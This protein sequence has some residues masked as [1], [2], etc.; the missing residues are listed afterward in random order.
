[1]TT[2]NFDALF[3][4][5][6]VALIGAS[7]RPG[8]VGHV[9]AHN[10]IAGGFDGPILPVN[11]HE[12]AIGGSLCYPSVDK[13]P[14]VPDLAVIATPPA[15]VPAIVAQLGALGCRA[16]VVV[17][18]GFGEGGDG[19]D[20][21]Q[22]MLDAAKPHL[23]RI[24]GPNCLGLMVPGMGLNASFAHLAPV[25]GD[26][27]F[28][29]QSGAIATTV[30]DW[31][32]GRGLGFSHIIS[33]GDMS[34]VD[35]G[36]LL[37]HLALDPAVRSILLYVETV[38][39]PR[40]FMSAARIA[41]RIKPVI[42][43]KAGRSQ[44]GAKAAFSHTG[45]LAGS[46]LVY[47][48]AFRRAGML[49]VRELRELFEAAETLAAGIEVRGDRLTIVTNGGGAGVMAVDALE[50]AGGRLAALS[51]G[52]RTALDAVLPKN[53]SRANPIDIIGDASGERY[54]KALEIVGGEAES[55]DAVLVMNCPTG[56]VDGAEVSGSVIE[57]A[58]AGTTP[59]LACWLGEAT[60][61]ANRARLRA[62]KVPAYETPDEA[63][64]AF[65]QLVT[66]GRN[67]ALLMETPPL[68]EA[69]PT[70]AADKAR[71][72]I[73]LVRGDGRSVLTA[74]EARA[75]LDAYA[76]P[77]LATEVAATPEDAARLA[78]AMAGPV[79]LKILSPDI[80]HKSDVGGV[81]LD[82]ATPEAVRTAAETM[83]TDVRAAAPAARITGFTVQAM[84]VRPRAQELILGVI[85]DR[86]FGPALLFGHGG[87]AVEVIGD[88]VMGLPPLN[89]VLA[90]EMMERTRVIRL[91]KGYRDRPPADLDA[92]A[93]TLV[94]LAQLAADL[95][96]I[97]ELDIN[98]LLADETGVLALDARV[99]L[100]P[101]D[102]EPRRLAIRPYPSGLERTIA[103]RDGRAFP[104]R[105]IRPTDAFLLAQMT[106]R[107]SPEDL[108]LRFLGPV[109]ELA[110]EAAARLTQI[111][112]DREMAFVAFEP[113]SGA[114]AGLARLIGD[115]N[116]ENAEFAVMV[117][118]DLKGQGLGYG[119]LSALI[120][121]ARSRGLRRLRG[122]VLRGNA[123]MLE[124]ARALGAGIEDAGETAM[125]ATFDLQA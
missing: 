9:L 44:G 4:P 33:L 105:P 91:L 18:A 70:D 122:E 32:A 2:R 115:P 124:L 11:P 75:L 71:A 28:V 53:W 81:R 50:T 45:A 112:Y 51:D 73:G 121:Y 85:D 119:L 69:V 97:G 72:L 49:R 19:G 5:K 96:E 64:R 65:M 8:S 43:V 23:M 6:A 113:N 37:D 62:G 86:T 41:A 66:Y 101:A 40:K 56:V 94:K 99:T 12:T 20:L 80:S 67:Q 84:A 59:V 95:P 98:P 78:E 10:L 116:N 46:D 61:A 77:T 63:V 74:P 48:A 79:A 21:R 125:R 117:R 92:V 90:R 13:L 14:V 27:A 109:T 123:A 58:H 57:T 39:S 118:S 42:V 1:M 107:S 87:T 108:R 111:D 120:A 3:A 16:A 7:N 25:P 83:L 76:I 88:R 36:D 60:A 106:A 26:I 15:T 47:D 100:R 82:L 22:A 103:T 31:A 35:F 17:T 29:T 110:E 68:A 34:D 114:M 55:Q 89:M 54:R 102:A 52:A 30:L 93:L 38:T 24:V 104:T